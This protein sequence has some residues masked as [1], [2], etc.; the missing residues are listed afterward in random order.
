M[1]GQFGGIIELSQ[2]IKN[3]YYFPNVF[4]V[5]AAFNSSMTSSA[6]PKI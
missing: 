6:L 5:A 1:S 3:G 2:G 4:L